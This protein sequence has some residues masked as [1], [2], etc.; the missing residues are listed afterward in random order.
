MANAGSNPVACT[1]YEEKMSKI[2][3]E[4][5]LKKLKALGIK[6]EMCKCGKNPATKP[7]LCPFSGEIFNSKELC[8]CCSACQKDC[9]NST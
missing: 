6:P 3:R 4:K 5:K 9:A 7:H 8:T 2:S 1:N